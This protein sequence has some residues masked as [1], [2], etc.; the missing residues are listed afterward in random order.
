M[1]SNTI[2]ALIVGFLGST[3]FWSFIT[4]F[5]ELKKTKKEDETKKQ[6]DTIIQKLDTV[7][8]KLTTTNEQL[9]KTDKVTMA[10]ARD[11]IYYL[12]RRSIIRKDMDPDNM[13]DLKALMEP[14]KANDGDGLADEYFEKYEYIFKTNGGVNA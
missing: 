13:R 5:I 10:L 1:D 4:K 3:G 12:S 2:V 14:Y 9:D 8:N 6:L 7:E 11:R